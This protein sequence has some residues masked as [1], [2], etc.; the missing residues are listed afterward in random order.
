MDFN[1]NQIDMIW[2]MSEIHFQWF[3]KYFPESETTFDEVLKLNHIKMIDIVSACDDCSE[4][5]IDFIFESVI[6]D[7][8]EMLDGYLD[9]DDWEDESN[10]LD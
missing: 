6:K 4:D 8:R 7:Y 2:E 5:M 3:E 9:D 10:L 1:Q